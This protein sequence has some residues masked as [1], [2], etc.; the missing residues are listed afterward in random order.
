MEL[1]RIWQ[2]KRK[3]ALLVTHDIPEAVFLS[4]WILVMSPRPGRIVD[5][6]EVPL[7]RPR[8]RSIIETPEFIRKVSLVRKL[9]TT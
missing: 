6:V 4:D 9:M 7:A 2:T 1:A 8:E 3:T 5:I